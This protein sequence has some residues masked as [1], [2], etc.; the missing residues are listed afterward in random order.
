MSSDDKN[1]N[2]KFDE[3]TVGS[4]NVDRASEK[5]TS[6]TEKLV[7]YK[8]VRS[9]VYTVKLGYNELGYNELPVIMNKLFSPKSKYNTIKCPSYNEL[10]VITN[11]FCLPK[12]FVITQFHCNIS[13]LCCKARCCLRFL[14]AHMEH[15]FNTFLSFGIKNTYT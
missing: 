14:L 9:F 13:L 6:Y 11:K 10:P 15:L 2:S 3:L 1:L 12:L 7:N 8:K 4:A 5:E